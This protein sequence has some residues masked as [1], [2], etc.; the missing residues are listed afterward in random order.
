MVTEIAMWWAL[1]IGAVVRS[2]TYGIIVALLSWLLTAWGLLLPGYVLFAVCTMLSVA[3]I[4]EMFS[5]PRL[6]PTLLTVSITLVSSLL[7]TGAIFQTWK[8]VATSYLLF[9][10]VCVIFLLLASGLAAHRSSLIVVHG[11]TSKLL[12]VC[13]LLQTTSAPTL[14]AVFTAGIVALSLRE[15]LEIR[16]DLLLLSASISPLMLLSL[17]TGSYTELD[18]TVLYLLTTVIAA[19]ILE[20]GRQTTVAAAASTLFILSFL[21]LPTLFISLSKLSILTV[22][23]TTTVPIMCFTLCLVLVRGIVFTVRWINHDPPINFQ[24]TIFWQQ[25]KLEINSFWLN[26]LLRRKTQWII[27]SQKVDQCRTY[28]IELYDNSISQVRN[29]SQCLNPRCG[30]N[31]FFHFDCK[32]QNTFFRKVKKVV[33]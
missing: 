22:V 18:T 19:S 11:L 25:K 10:Y 1:I 17:P 12:V 3:M 6:S 29:W 5:S 4:L 16:E 21:G 28:G 27:Q 13:I 8:I 26:N 7:L 32:S 14:A 31:H 24:L 15:S 30:E 9:G 2:C 33:K 20:A 23:G